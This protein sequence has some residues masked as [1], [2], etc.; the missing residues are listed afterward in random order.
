MLRF[1]GKV[2]TKISGW[3]Y[4]PRLQ[5][6]WSHS[7]TKTLAHTV[8]SQVLFIFWV[9]ALHGWSLLLESFSMNLICNAEN[10]I[11]PLTYL[12]LLWYCPLWCDILLGIKLKV[13]LNDTVSLNK[14]F[15]LSETSFVLHLLSVKWDTRSKYILYID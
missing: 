13:K 9:L 6:E 12:Q 8:L 7:K 10:V 2:L 5:N 1:S 4:F 3:D 11:L 15:S 14:P